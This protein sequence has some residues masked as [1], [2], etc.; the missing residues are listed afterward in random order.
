VQVCI[1]ASAYGANSSVWWFDAVVAV[2]TSVF[3]LLYGLRTLFFHGHRWW[4]P[5]FWKDDAASIAEHH[6]QYEESHTTK[7]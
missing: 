2:I 3:L 7:V 6:T 5:S 1:S 4:K